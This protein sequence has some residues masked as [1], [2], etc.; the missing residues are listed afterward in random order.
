MSSTQAERQ[1]ILLSAGTAARR[2]AMAAQ[3]ARLMVE[4]DWPRLAE[5][6]RRR[7][8]L[9]ILGPRVLELAGGSAGG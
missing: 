2:Q 4:I 9:T 5:T 3:A 7:K 6:L 8:L 1:V